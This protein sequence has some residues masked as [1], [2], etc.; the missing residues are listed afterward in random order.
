MRPACYTLLQQS[1]SILITAP[2]QI[3]ANED[4][5]PYSNEEYTVGWICALPVEFAA[6]KGMLDEEHGNPQMPPSKADSNSYLLGS[7]GKFKVVVACLPLDQLGAASA[8]IC[9]KEMLFTFPKIRGLLVGIGAGIPGVGDSP[10]I[11]LGDVVVS[12]SKESRGVV[13]YDFGRQLADGSA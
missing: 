13:V 5:S 6:A 8:A 11:H 4:Q 3:M 10:D 7:I 1:G 12:S 9:A 2:S